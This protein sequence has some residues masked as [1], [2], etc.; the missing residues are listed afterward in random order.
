MARRRSELLLLAKEQKFG[1]RE[2]SNTTSSCR[3]PA[4]EANASAGGSRNGQLLVSYFMVEGDSVLLSV[5]TV[6]IMLPLSEV[7]RPE[8]CLRNPMVS[9]APGH[10]QRG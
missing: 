6:G 8:C 7:K 4:T 2:L 9:P 10:S 1:C 5:L 3:D